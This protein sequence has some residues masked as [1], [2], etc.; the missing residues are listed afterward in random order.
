MPVCHSRVVAVRCR[1]LGVIRHN[2]VSKFILRK[3]VVSGSQLTGHALAGKNG[4]PQLLPAFR[5]EQVA[6]RL[7][8][9]QA[10]T[11]QNADAGS[12]K[13]KE[14]VVSS[15]HGKGAFIDRG[16]H[17]VPAIGRPADAD[18][19]AGELPGLFR[20]HRGNV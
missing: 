8:V 15:P 10:Y 13:R 3:G 11:I 1:Q 20:I 14:Q 7:S 17:P 16:I 19:G 5:I 2:I 4:V 6:S 12:R 18:R 9:K